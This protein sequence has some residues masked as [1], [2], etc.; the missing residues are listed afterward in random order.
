MNS[1]QITTQMQ[2]HRVHVGGSFTM[3][4]ILVC[5]AIL[6]GL[7]FFTLLFWPLAL[8]CLLR[9]IQKSVPFISAV[10]VEMR[11]P[12]HHVSV[13]RVTPR[14]LQRLSRRPTK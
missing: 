1:E 2:S 6:F 12:S 8:M 5:F 4:F 14:S 3:A 10:T 9:S 13:L 11:L 7:V